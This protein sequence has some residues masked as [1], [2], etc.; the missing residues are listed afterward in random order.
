V[1]SAPRHRL[2]VRIT[3]PFDL[4]MK[5]GLFGTAMTTLP[6]SLERL[7]LGH[8]FAV[9]E[10]FQSLLCPLDHASR[11]RETKKLTSRELTL[12]GD[13][14]FP[15]DKDALE[16][17]ISSTWILAAYQWQAN[18]DYLQDMFRQLRFDALTL[19]GMRT[20]LPLIPL[21]QLIVGM[22]DSLPRA[23]QESRTQE[24]RMWAGQL[25]RLSLQPS[26]LS[27]I[28]C[29]VAGEIETLDKELNDEI[30]LIIGAVTV[31]DSDANK[32]QSERATLLTLLAAVYLPLT[33]VTGIFGMNIKDINEGNPSWRAC[34]EVLGVVAACT[35]VFVVVYRRWRRWRRG[36]QERKRM[37]LGFRKDV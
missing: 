3:R 33:L 13:G 20:Y 10:C 25:L 22:R 8:P 21:R 34:G 18:V 17:V 7:E 15:H 6:V 24:N 32:Q 12:S 19:P 27:E 36:R 9:F 11:D 5:I 30:H 28:L 23:Q 4:V 14:P 2:S 16:M 26:N 35:I 31:Q 37:E 1:E 29:K